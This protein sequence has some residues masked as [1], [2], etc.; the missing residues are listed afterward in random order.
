MRSAERMRRILPPIERQ[1]RRTNDYPSDASF[2][3]GPKGPHR[4]AHATCSS[5]VNNT[6]RCFSERVARYRYDKDLTKKPSRVGRRD[7]F[8]HC[9]SRRANHRAVVHNGDNPTTQLRTHSLGD[10]SCFHAPAHTSIRTPSD[11]AHIV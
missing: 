1:K 8:A 3:S 6:E 9:D 10:T 5:L 2:R 4:K 7:R 11:S